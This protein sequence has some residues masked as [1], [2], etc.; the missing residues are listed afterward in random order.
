M[1][2]DASLLD[3]KPKLNFGACHTVGEYAVVMVPGT[4]HQQFVQLGHAEI[5]HETD[6]FQVE[7]RYALNLGKI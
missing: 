2:G 4:L 5:F 3:L 7:I 1:T 6:P